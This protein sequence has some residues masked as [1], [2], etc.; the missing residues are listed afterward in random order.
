MELYHL[1]IGIDVSEKLSASIFRNYSFNAQKIKAASLSKTSA[2]NYRSMRC[3]IPGT[4]I[5]ITF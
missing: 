1:L 5:F 3:H 4:V 2:A